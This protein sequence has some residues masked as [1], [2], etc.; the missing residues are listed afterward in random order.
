[1]EAFL[2]HLQQ[3]A[4]GM[5]SSK[6][7]LRDEFRAWKHANPGEFAPGTLFLHV[8]VEL[9]S[10]GHL[11][12]GQDTDVLQ[13]QIEPTYSTAEFKRRFCHLLAFGPLQAKV[14][15][16]IPASD[17]AGGM[18]VGRNFQLVKSNGSPEL[19]KFN[20]WIEE[21]SEWS[22]NPIK[23]SLNR[24]T[25][26]A[27][28]DYSAAWL[29]ALHSAAWDYLQ[30]EKLKDK[31]QLLLKHGATENGYLPVYAPPPGWGGGGLNPDAAG[32][33][34]R[35]YRNP[36]PSEGGHA[37][38]RFAPLSFD[39]VD[40]E[41][42][43]G[44]DGVDSAFG[45]G[46]GGSSG[47]QRSSRRAMAVAPK[48]NNQI[49]GVSSAPQLRYLVCHAE[50]AFAEALA[51]A[52]AD[53]PV[54]NHRTKCTLLEDA[55]DA[56]V[57]ALV[58]TDPWRAVHMQR[59]AQGLASDNHDLDQLKKLFE[60]LD[61]IRDH[62]ELERDRALE[63]C[64]RELAKLEE[65]MERVRRMKEEMGPEAYQAMRAQRRADASRPSLYESIRDLESSIARLEQLPDLT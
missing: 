54:S 45:G 12:S 53:T 56:V 39:G 3:L 42:D 43:D 33:I 55:Y 64:R 23:V 19:L 60:S 14:T 5:P 20:T 21:S 9:F 36:A 6:T 2:G 7:G 28:G 57:K 13:W 63:A 1:M 22:S 46:F 17:P 44:S 11:L 52:A 47:N 27:E 51:C 37:S 49:E 41:A 10:S 50:A 16:T 25:E 62:L 65:K 58:R 15:T 48:F 38:N 24:V 31:A 8:W 34:D 59:G 32:A 4:T 35:P 30:V 61:L 26:V 29:S 40:S 18:Q